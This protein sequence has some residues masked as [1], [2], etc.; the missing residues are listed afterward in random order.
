MIAIIGILVAL[1]LPAVQ[2]ARAAARRATCTNNLKQVGLAMHSHHDQHGHFPMGMSG[3]MQNGYDAP[4]NL[5]GEMSWMPLILP[6]IEAQ[7][8]FDQFDFNADFNSTCCGSFPNHD[9][10]IPPLICP[11]DSNSPKILAGPSGYGTQGFHG[12]YVMCA[13]NTIYNPRYDRQGKDLN[14]VFYPQSEIRIAEITDGTSKTLMAGELKVVTDLTTHDLRGRY[15]NSREGSCL[16]STVYPPNT[17]VA[18][19][20]I[21]CDAASAA[22]IDAPCRRGSEYNQ[23]LRSYHAGGIVVVGLCDASVRTID[24]NIDSVVYQRLGSRHDGETVG[25]Y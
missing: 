11:S 6:F 22:S 9:T 7:A 12:N 15:Y 16:F 21:W 4:G 13:G 10:V 20:A 14:G 17:P 5:P 24:E 25:T 1:L 3:H 8:L 2:A 23:S 18:D 19:V